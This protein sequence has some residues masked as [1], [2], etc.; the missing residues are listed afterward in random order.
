MTTLTLTHKRG[1]TFNLT[2]A[3]LDSSGV[4]VDLTDY[5]LESQVRDMQGELLSAFTC[6]KTVPVQGTYLISASAD[7]TGLWPPGG[8]RFDVQFT[9]LDGT[10]TSSDTVALKIV[11]DI[12]R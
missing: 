11:E 8:Y 5:T 6:T 2:G 3:C 12:T 1:D 9:A 7:T 4:P 10:V